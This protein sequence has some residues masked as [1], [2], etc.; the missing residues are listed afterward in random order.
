MQNNIWIFWEESEKIQDYER[1]YQNEN[2]NNVG[3]ETNRKFKNIHK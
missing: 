2:K 1:S 3:E